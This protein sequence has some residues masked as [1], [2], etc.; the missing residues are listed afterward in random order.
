MFENEELILDLTVEKSK[1]YNNCKIKVIN[2]LND[3]I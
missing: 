3:N 2:L 1:L